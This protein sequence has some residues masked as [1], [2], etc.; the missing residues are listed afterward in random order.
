M[1][2]RIKQRTVYTCNSDTAISLLQKDF[3]LQSMAYFVNGNGVNHYKLVRHKKLYQ[4]N[5]DT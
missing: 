1:K 3:K 4:K 2:Y 5:Y